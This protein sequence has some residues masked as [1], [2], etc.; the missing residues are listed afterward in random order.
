MKQLLAATLLCGWCCLSTAQTTTN[1]LDTFNRSGSLSGSSPNIGDVNSGT[2]TNWSGSSFTTTTANGGAMIAANASQYAALPFV[3]QNGYVYTLGVTMAIQGGST[4]DRWGAFGFDNGSGAGNIF[5]TKGPWMLM[6]YTG[7]MEAFYNGLTSIY[8]ADNVGNVAPNNNLLQIILDTTTPNAWKAQFKVNGVQYGSTFTLPMGFAITDVAFFCYGSGISVTNTGLSVTSVHPTAPVISGQPAGL[9]NWAGVN[10]SLNVAASG[11]QP[12]VYQWY[13]NS[14]GNPLSGQTNA[15]LNF[16]PLQ[17]TNSGSYFVVITNIYG[18]V[19]SSV[20]AVRAETNTV[21]ALTPSISVGAVPASNSDTSVVSSDYT[22]CALDFSTSTTPFGINGVTFSPVSVSGTSASGTDSANGGAWSLTVASVF[23]CPL[24]T[25]TSSVGAQADGAM[26]TMLNDAAAL[27]GGIQIQIGDSMTLTFSNAVPASRYRLRLFYQ[28]WNTSSLPVVFTFNGQGSNETVQ[29]DENLGASINSSGAYYVDYVFTAAANSVSAT[30]A[31]TLAGN[32]AVLCGAMLQQVGAPPVPTSIS[33][34]ALPSTGTDAATGI[35]ATNTYLCALDFGNQ[36]TPVSVNGVSFQKISVSGSGTGANNNHPLFSGTDTVFSGVWTLAASLSDGSTGMDS[37]SGSASS[38]ADGSMASLLSDFAYMAGLGIQPGDNATLTLGYLIPGASYSL[39]CYYRQW[40]TSGTF[41]RRPINFFFNGDGTNRPYAN[42]PLDI[43]AGGAGYVQYNF[44]AATNT[45]S[46]QAIETVAGNG[47]HIY[48]VTLQQISGPEKPAIF[49]QPQGFTNSP[50]GSGTLSVLVSGTPRFHFQW[51]KNSSP[52]A[53]ATNSSLI[54]SNLNPP[55]SGAYWVVVTNVAGS[56]TSSVAN[57]L[58]AETPKPPLGPLDTALLSATATAESLVAA[59]DTN[60]ATTNWTAHWIGPSGSAANLWLCYRKGFSLATTPANAIARI[61]VDSKYWLWINGRMVVREGNLKRGPTTSDTWYDEINLAPYLQS[62]SNTIALLQWYFGKSAFSHVSSGAPGMIFE[63]NAGGTF[64][65]SDT[66][67]RMVTN[68]AFQTASVVAQPNFRL[69][70][71][72][73]RYDMRLDLGA[74]TNSIYNDSG[75][76]APTDLGAVGGTPFGNLWRRPLP[77][78]KNTGLTNFVSTNVS[79]GNNWTCQLPFNMRFTLWLDVSNATPG[80]VI[81]IQT[82]ANAG[83]ENPL[84]HEYVT[85]AGRQSFEMPSWVN[86]NYAYLTIPTNVTVYGLKYRPHQSDT[87][88]LGSFDCSDASLVTLWTKSVNTLGVNMHDTW[89][90]CPDRERANWIG[91]VTVDLGQTPYVFDPRAEL[92]TRESI[93][94]VIRWQRGDDTMFAP[95]PGTWTSELPAQIL[96]T[97]GK[98]GVQRY[99]RNTGDTNFLVQAYPALRDYLLNVWQTDSQGLVVHRDGGWNW[100]DWGS[101]IDAPLLDNTWYLMACEAAAQIAPIVGQSADVPVF[102][103]RA[104][105]IRNSFNTAFWTGSAY[106]S[107]SYSGSTDERGNAMAVLAGLPDASMTNVLRTVLTTQINA[108]PYME[109]YV[110]EALFALGDPD[111]ALNRMRSRYSSMISSSATTLWENFPASG[112]FNHAWS[113]GPLTLL[114]EEVAGVTPTSP[115]F[116]TFDVQP[117]L[118]TTLNYVNLDVPSRHGVIRIG[119]YRSGAHNKVSVRAPNGATGRLIQ[120]AGGALAGAILSLAGGVTATLDETV[121]PAEINVTNGTATLQASFSSTAR[122]AKTGPGTL[123]L[124]SA[125]L[126]AAGFDVRQGTLT[127]G[128]GG[129]LTVSGN[130]TNTATLRLTGNAQLNVSG[131]LVNTGVLDIINWNGALP[132]GFVNT[133]VVLD[134]SSVQAKAYSFSNRVF[135]L[136]VN[137]YQGHVYQLQRSASLNPAVW[138][139]IGSAQTGGGAD[140]L[141]SHTNSVGTGAGF[142]RVNILP[143]F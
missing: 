137:G 75:W 64:V 1:I 103:S 74:W 15:T 96:A 27:S 102:T 87:E 81:T 77:F 71:T 116:A 106:R 62:G 107:S 68:T 34:T 50:G 84:S 90:D 53:G 136:T 40:D 115:G 126:G 117:A 54:L 61:A 88:V 121:Q 10:G 37:T 110:L 24:A 49:T 39:R 138:T 142:Y 134:R 125:S 76:A 23:S 32:S 3:A 2:A 19:T 12:L 51:W 44:T 14:S 42:N 111:D 17:G 67:W 13:K 46:M 36:S 89:S 29:V 128:S 104:Q 18:A 127:I 79:N 65:R 94:D 43:D 48:G 135:S 99:F 123:D 26:A 120:P 133:G 82:D 59:S 25:V 80:Q 35:N 33:V 30:L 52:V 45:V 132:A 108:S 31:T 92:T 70:E 95:V 98:Y 6:K 124:G 21:M 8:A 7:H 56:V 69:P 97:V 9:T 113:G 57:V 129:Q 63:M 140:L 38:Q 72:S 100:Y 66:T 141:F 93:L 16:S 118:G 4:S 73:L 5:N 130:I 114:A 47:P 119:I 105:G 86:G 131:S 20:V 55:D 78:W 85:G 112:T 58:V 122:I 83:G 60:Q 28:Q 91:D 139:D 11:S 22:L 143:L 109:K 101:N 41:P